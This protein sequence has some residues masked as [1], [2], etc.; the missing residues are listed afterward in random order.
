MPTPTIAE[1]VR[2]YVTNG[3]PSSGAHDPTKADWRAWGTWVEQL[4]A[5]LAAGQGGVTEL[6]ELI[7]YFTVTG[8]TANAIV[9][10]PNATP[11][12]AP[13]AALLTMTATAVNTGAVTLNGKPLRANGGE[14]LQAGE[15]HVG[16]L[17][18][19][20]DLGAEYRLITDPGSLRNKLA[21]MEWATNPEDDPVSLEAGGDGATTFS[22][23]HWAAKSSEDADRSEDALFQFISATNPAFAVKLD[24]VAVSGQSEYDLL[25]PAPEVDGHLYLDVFI[26]GAKQ[27]KDGVAYA[28]TNGGESILFPTGLPEGTWLYAEGAA[29]FGMAATGN[30]AGTIANDSEVPGG[31]VRDGMNRLYSGGIEAASA[32]KAGQTL[33]ITEAGELRASGDLTEYL[34]QVATRCGA[35]QSLNTT[36]KQIMSRSRHFARDDIS[37]L[38]LMYGNWWI[39]SSQEEPSGGTITVTASIEYPEGQFTQ[40][41]WN[42]GATSCTI[43][44]F[45]N[46]PL[47]D[48][49]SLQIP[50]GAEFFVRTYASSANGILFCP[51]R[52][53]ANGERCGF[54]PTA[55][56][57]MTMSGAYDTMPDNG[58]DAIFRPLAI[59]APTK[60]RSVLIVGDSRSFGIGDT[61]SETS[62]QG[63][64]DRSI[65][66]ACGTI[67]VSRS[68]VAAFE[69][70][71][72]HA[73]RLPLAQYCSTVYVHLGI[74][75]ALAGNTAATII[76]NLQS[77]A[78][79][80]SAKPVWTAT[81]E[82]V[83]TSTDGW[84]TAANQ[85]VDASDGVRQAINTAIRGGLA[86]FAG[87]FDVAYGVEGVGSGSGKWKVV[88]GRPLT[89]DGIHEN[90]LGYRAL[91]E[92]GL[93]N[94][95]K[96]YDVPGQ[97]PKFATP[98]QA[99]AGAASGV[100]LDPA[101]LAGRPKFKAIKGGATLNS[102]TI[103]AA[104][105]TV[106]TFGFES[107]DVGGF[108][109]TTTARF[110]PPP[111]LYRLKGQATVTAGITDGALATLSVLKN[112]AVASQFF[113]RTSGA[114]GFSITHDD[115]VEANG[116]DYFQL[117][118]E[119]SGAG[120][121]TVTG[122]NLQTFFEGY[123]I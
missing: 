112:G 98:A 96:F 23:L 1:V 32:D 107:V 75:D 56:A 70:L 64:V 80:F 100:P 43:A 83:T 94:P 86:G 78:A 73:L 3:V 45:S 51:Q 31:T 15:I 59:V 82:P 27:P 25:S 42:G 76:G 8:G 72:S 12:T 21:A 29:T 26:G 117:A 66:R 46:A 50:E 74:N 36:N 19:F 34:G 28:V 38:Q 71:A 13:G 52:D 53:L 91:Q 41:R 85:T 61:P 101:S 81:L 97:T 49:V 37:S 68:G 5:A 79:L 87:F 90:T 7:Y 11:P 24:T 118:F 57:D 115:I 35:S 4:L 58:T 65:S 104:T 122:N 102:Q 106:L 22:A 6:P 123:A 16:D 109:D 30:T 114:S 77:V 120:D 110:T 17:L 47:S 20:L 48:A 44:D 9:A 113:L 40:V 2:D 92:S 116:A 10:T 60:K 14:E 119:M 55:I 62:D 93:V 33:V 99:V 54:G 63:N 111:G 89:S 84:T 103:S 67:N 95:R 121:K 105:Q 108:F 88:A 69:F 39:S 18:A